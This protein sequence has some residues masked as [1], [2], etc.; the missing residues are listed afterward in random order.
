MSSST[1]FRTGRKVK[2]IAKSKVYIKDLSQRLAS[3][4]SVVLILMILPGCVSGGMD[5]LGSTGVDKSVSTNT[6]SVSGS[7]DT[8][9]DEVTVRNAVTSADLA[10]MQGTPLPWANTATGSAGVVSAINEASEEGRICRTFETSRHSYR[11]IAK[12]AGK[13]CMAGDGNWQ[14]LS[15]QPNG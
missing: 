14:L 8:V 12:F 9:S 6:V 10:K 13:A 1:G 7:T 2:V 15:F 3:S 11:G 4:A 5:F